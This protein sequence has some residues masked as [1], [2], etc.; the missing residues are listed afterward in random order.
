M[1]ALTGSGDHWVR[2]T[3]DFLRA[4]ADGSISNHDQQFEEPWLSAP[5]LAL[6]LSNHLAPAGLLTRSNGALSITPAADEWL[7]DPTGERLVEVF[8][9]H[10]RL[11]GEL[12]SFI[13]SEP[14]TIKAMLEFAN[15]EYRLGWESYDQIRR[16]VKWFVIAGLAEETYEHHYQATA[17]GRAFLASVEVQPAA[18]IWSP[19]PASDLIDAPEPIAQ[20]FAEF[21]DRPDRHEKRHRSLG[22]V[23]TG[24]SGSTLDSLRT[25]TSAAIPRIS[26]RA[27]TDLCIES[28]GVKESSA[29][30]ALSTLR[31]SGLLLQVSRTDYAAT[32]AAQSWIESSD[33]LNLIRILHAHVRFVGELLAELSQTPRTSDLARIGAE[34]FGIG[35]S[36]AN[37]VPRIVQILRQVGVVHEVAWAQHEVTPVGELLLRELPLAGLSEA[38]VPERPTTPREPKSAT[39]DLVGMLRA[40]SVDSANYEKLEIAVRDAFEL[41]GFDAQRRGGPGNTDVIV[42]LRAGVFDAGI[43]IVDAKSSGSGVIT[44]KQIN[45]QA[46][47]DHR[48]RH[49]ADRAAVVGPD[50]SDG[51]LRTW[52][53]EQGVALISVEQLAQVL[54]AHDAY[55]LAPSEILVILDPER[56]MVEMESIIEEKA[57]QGLMVRAIMQTLEREASEND[58]VLGSALDAANLYRSLRDSITPRPSLDEIQSIVDLLAAPIL[59]VLRVDK[60]GYSVQES[61]ASSARR[62]RAIADAIDAPRG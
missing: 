43:A 18:E 17:A 32:A 58:P 22:Y 4:I 31:S 8:H 24:S 53:T 14:R 51:R 52:A 28:F 3:E 54:L 1:P 57:R 59:S 50:F 23:P 47:G 49:G 34:S 29:K 45:F 12:L 37:N 20:L 26:Q 9:R 19:P 44:E 61:S 33:D 10:V 38:A 11:V 5:V 39:L 25:L 46:L 55:G 42:H 16:R 13:A 60:A 62:L 48:T 56:G 15:S 40:A 41:L 36:G 6:T 30:S 2:F 7:K 21:Y 35:P 27:F